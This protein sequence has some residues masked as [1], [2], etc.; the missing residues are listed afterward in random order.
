MSVE[1][2]A[3]DIAAVLKGLKKVHYVQNGK[4]FIVGEG[5]GGY[6]A[7]LAAQKASVK[8][9]ALLGADLHR[10]D[11]SKQL[12]PKVKDI[13]TVVD[14]GSIVLGKGF[15]KASRDFDPLKKASKVG[16]PVLVVHGTSDEVASYEYAAKL[17]Q[18]LPEGTLVPVDGAPHRFSGAQ[19]KKAGQEICSFIADKL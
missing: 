11:E 15:Y 13:P 9:M 16:E 1:T 7:L 17:A 3:A 18:L 5:F 2:E 19:R 6:A 14:K 12:Y 4:I 8:G 10:A